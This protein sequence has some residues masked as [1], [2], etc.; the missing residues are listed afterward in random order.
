VTLSVFVMAFF[1]THKKEILIP[2]IEV[3]L[4]QGAG[5]TYPI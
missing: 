3:P 2:V 1:L 4:L 5:P